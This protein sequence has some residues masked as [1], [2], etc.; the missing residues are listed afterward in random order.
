MKQIIKGGGP[1]ENPVLQ[2][3]L[4]EAELPPNESKHLFKTVGETHWSLAVCLVV[5]VT[6]L[7]STQVCGVVV[8]VIFISRLS[9]AERSA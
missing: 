8:L 9:T 1:W 6:A 4:K 3:I 2:G 5:K 7:C